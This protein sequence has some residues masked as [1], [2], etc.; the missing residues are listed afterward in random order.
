[1][2]HWFHDIPTANRKT[3]FYNLHQA[4]WNYDWIICFEMETA[5]MLD[6]QFH[7]QSRKYRLLHGY[8]V[9]LAA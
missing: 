5:Q 9:D 8:M 3:N 7:W 4:R 2:V 6:N 1:M